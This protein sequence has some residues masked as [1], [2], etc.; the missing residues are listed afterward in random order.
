M[1]RVA[2]RAESVRSSE[3]RGVAVGSR[4][5]KMRRSGVRRQPQH[6]SAD[7]RSDDEH[8]HA[9]LSLGLG[10]SGENWAPMARALIGGLT[11]GSVL[12]LIVIPV[13]YATAEWSSASQRDHR[14]A[15]RAR[16]QGAGA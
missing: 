8:G 13:I 5:A 6:L 1:C 7:D 15:R 16:R 10:E 14:A 11:V 2:G 12:T 9:P 4:T 3:I